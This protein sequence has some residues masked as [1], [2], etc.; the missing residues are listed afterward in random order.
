M[1]SRFLEKRRASSPVRPRVAAFALLIAATL[2]ILAH[3]RDLRVCADPDNL[4]FSNTKQQGFENR[5]AELAARDLHAQLQ[6]EW[7][8]MGRGFVR[9][10]LNAGRCDLLIGIPS[11]FRAVL[12]TTPYY[13]S[14]YV[15]VARRDNGLKLASLDDPS[16]HRLKIGIQALDE[17]YTPPA[18]AL[19][20]RGLQNEI[21]PFD[22][23]GDE[24]DSIIRAVAKRQVD[25]AIVWGPLA[26][27]YARKFGNA[28]QLTPVTPQVDPPNLPF[29]FSISMG[30]RKGNTALQH[31]LDNFLQRRRSDIRR[32]L[33]QYGV[34]QLE[35][36]PSAEGGQ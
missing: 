36:A 15:F 24:A 10:F 2:P 17:D 32:I 20:R 33:D 26:G 25:T 9:D 5:I 19:A 30:V 14:S 34:P 4:P 6:Y 16:L 31:E 27:F 18:T 8:R 11:N 23:T 7:Q 13:R 28:L 12:T 29:T 21:V 22:S 3:A 1:C 35:L